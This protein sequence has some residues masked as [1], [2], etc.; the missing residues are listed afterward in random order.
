MART[1]IEYTAADLDAVL[2]E[3]LIKQG[4]DPEM[5]KLR[6]PRW[7]FEGLGL[8]LTPAQIETETL[9][10][11]YVSD[12]A[13]AQRLMKLTPS[14]TPTAPVVP[15]PAP[16]QPANTPPVTVLATPRY[17]KPRKVSEEGRERMRAAAKA[18]Q[19]KI[20]QQR[21]EAEL[22]RLIAEEEAARVKSNGVHR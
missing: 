2:W 1:S 6:P 14:P 3:H 12:L 4:A 8:K 20:R 21:E 15:Q 10:T 7:N 18:R 13:T 22:A 19:E 11:V 5:L 9:V 17:Q 16:I